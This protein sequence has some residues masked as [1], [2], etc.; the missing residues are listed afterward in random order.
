MQ[1]NDSAGGH[2]GPPLQEVIGWYKTMTTNEY[3][4]AVKS[5]ELPA[6]S[7]HIWQRGYYEHIVRKE[8]DY[9][10]I[11]QYIDQNPAQWAEDEYYG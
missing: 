2:I 10:D 11:W 5:N 4:R 6:F 3:I 8:E 1:Q 7:G 9:L